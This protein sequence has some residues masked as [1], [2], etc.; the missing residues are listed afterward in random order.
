MIEPKTKM[1]MLIKHL[2]ICNLHIANLQLNL[3][4]LR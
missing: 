2:H 3:F 1:Q 4:I